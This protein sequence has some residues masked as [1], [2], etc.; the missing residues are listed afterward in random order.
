MP[1]F[2]R[3]DR[4]ILDGLLPSPQFGYRIEG[5]GLMTRRGAACE[6]CDE[7]RDDSDR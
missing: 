2:L 4:A 7:G 3:F 5:T 6:V 1:H